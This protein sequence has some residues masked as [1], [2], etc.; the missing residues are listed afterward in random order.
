MRPLH[1]HVL[2]PVF[3]DQDSLKF[4]L[5]HLDRAGG[6]HN[7][8]FTVVAVDDA[9]T[10]PVEVH[11]SQIDSLP[12]VREVRVLQLHCNAGHQRAIAIGLAYLAEQVHPALTVVMDADGEDRPEAIAALVD[13]FR[14]GDAQVV[15]ARRSK[16]H[17]SA[18]FRVFY[19]LFK[20]SYRVMTGHGLAFGNFVLLPGESLRGLVTRAELWNNLPATIV[21]SRLRLKPLAIERGRRY[22]GHS[23]M[24]LT[25]LVLHGLTSISVFSD[26]ALVRVLLFAGAFMALTAAAIVAVSSI[27]FLTTLAIPGWASATVGSL[28][29]LCLQSCLFVVSLIFILLAGRA[30]QQVIPLKAYPDYILRVHAV[31][32]GAGR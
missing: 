29:I 8:D 2:T 16:R 6:E 10:P 18:T 23:K 31:S 3:N 22:T 7:F 19:A 15:A 20:A 11:Q 25:S 28:S 5:E 14:A 17:E 26:V 27:R 12:H 30:Q 32:R 1:V 24:S 9:S 4:L 21:R 13:A